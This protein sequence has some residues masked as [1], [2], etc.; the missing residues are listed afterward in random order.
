[1]ALPIF[2]WKDP[3]KRDNASAR[4]MFSFLISFI[5]S[6][7]SI[8]R[9]S[10]FVK[11]FNVFSD[12]SLANPFAVFSVVSVAIFSTI[13]FPDFLHEDTISGQKIIKAMYMNL[14]AFIEFRSIVV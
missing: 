10:F 12:A 13:S 9:S 8:D 3:S 2:L 6:F 1:M 11:V 7:Q 14:K 5:K 4:L